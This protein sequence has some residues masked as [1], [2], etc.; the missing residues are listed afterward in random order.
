[1]NTCFSIE[2]GVYLAGRFGIRS[3]IDACIVPGAPGG[4]KARLE[5]RG[6]GP[7]QQEVQLL[8]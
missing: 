8:R 1:M 5:V 6:G 3:E 7:L 2:P 4:P